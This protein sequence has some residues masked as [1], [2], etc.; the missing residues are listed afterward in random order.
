MKLATKSVSEVRRPKLGSRY[1]SYIQTPV[2][3]SSVLSIQL[4]ELGL[5]LLTTDSICHQRFFIIIT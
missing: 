4:Y 2:Q 5:L 3:C 1:L